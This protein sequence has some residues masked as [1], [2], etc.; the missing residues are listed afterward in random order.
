MTNILSE[1]SLAKL[2]RVDPQL[3]RV[4]KR[5]IGISKVDFKVVEGVR[6]RDTMWEYWGK[7]RTAA[8]CAAAGVPVKYAKPTLAKITWLK[9]P[10]MSNHRIMADGFGKAVDLLP[11]PFDW[12]EGPQWK[13]L[14]DAMEEAA[15]LEGVD[16]RWGRDWDQD[17]I[18]GEKGET[19]GP[20][21]E[22]VL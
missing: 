21:W 16:I 2:D 18:I 7:G 14:N 13:L 5:A 9:N 6:S 4:V 3:V 1:K 22:L 20:H 8:Q 19:D 15:R 10:L 11:A 17:G 12:A